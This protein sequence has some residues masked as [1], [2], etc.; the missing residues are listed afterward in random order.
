MAST[1]E[2]T[3]TDPRIGLAL[4]GGGY[5]ATA[6]GLGCLRALHDRGLL[7]HV[8]VVSGI[9][10]GSLL[11]AMWAYGPP[12]FEEFDRAVTAL[13]RHD[14]QR[15]LLGAVLRPPH[16]LRGALS[17]KRALPGLPRRRARTFTRTELLVRALKARGF[18]DRLLDQVTHP[19]LDT[20]LSAT[21]L[22]T[23]NAV[24]F[25]SVC[26]SCSPHGRILDPVLVA[27]AVAASAAYPLLLPALSP[28]FRRSQAHEGLI[29]GV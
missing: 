14:L 12:S 29:V 25:G 7:G 5:R 18:G 11:A 28:D 4:S 2:P 27:D 3:V 15:E 19:G 22:I 1:G 13:L 24:R 23:T 26:S 10:G 17:T 21:D 16:L 8:K 20:V 9:S 6:F